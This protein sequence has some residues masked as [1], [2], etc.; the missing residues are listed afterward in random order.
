MRFDTDD[1]M[2]LPRTSG[3]EF[4]RGRVEGRD[5]MLGSYVQRGDKDDFRY[6]A[7]LASIDGLPDE[8]EVSI[9]LLGA[10]TS[11]R[12][13]RER[14][15]C[16]RARDKIVT[17]PASKTEMGDLEL[18]VGADLLGFIEQATEEVLC[19]LQGGIRIIGDRHWTGVAISGDPYPFNR[20]LKRAVA[21]NEK[22]LAS[23]RIDV[24]D[25]VDHARTIMADAAAI[26]RRFS[27]HE[28]PAP[29]RSRIKKRP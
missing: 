8:V 28:P 13:L 10:V 5:R 9:G 4:L 29:P 19:S 15:S 25:M 20:T 11:G 27:H 26:D 6:S 22:A 7:V 14:V 3:Y 12:P 17:A 2:D 23:V 1:H 16:P 24:E 21:R 18:V